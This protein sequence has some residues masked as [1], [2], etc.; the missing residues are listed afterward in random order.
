MTS[1]INE[2]EL[3]KAIEQIHPD[4]ELFEVRIINKVGKKSN[5]ISGYFKDAETLLKKLKTINLENTNVY[6]TLNQLNEGLFSRQQSET[7]I[8]GAN[9]TSDNDVDGLNWLFIDLD[10]KRAAGI[11][12]SKEELQNAYNLASKVYEYLKNLGFEEPVKAVS[13]NGAHLLYRIKLANN[14]TNRALVEKC[15]KT[16]SMIFD[17][18]KI[19]VDT[20]TF[21]PARIC[22]LYGTMAQKGKSTESR[23]HRMSHIIGEVKEV[24]ATDRAYLEKLVGELPQEAP[25]P[26]KYNNYSPAEFDIENWL[27]KYGLN[28]TKKDFRDGIKYVLDECPFDSS[29]K[30]PDSMVT[31]T[32][33]GAIGFKCLHNSCA[34]KHWRDLRLKFEPDAYEYSNEDRRI[35][36]GY[37]RHNREQNK[38]L[39]KNEV[40][41]PTFVNANMILHTDDPEGEYIKSGINVIDKKMKGLQKGCVSLVSGLRGAAKT[42]ILGQII[43]NCVEHK[44]TAVVYSGELSKKRFLNWLMIQA[45]GK[46]YT[47]KYREYEG[48]YCQDL[49]KPAICNWLGNYMWLYNNICGN[50]FDEIAALIKAK[51]AEYKADICI[52]DNLMAL[53]LGSY[54][55]DQYVAQ[56]QFVWK[57]KEIA[58]ELNV[59]VIFV[60]HPRKAMGFLRLDD[61][62]GSGNITNIVDNAFIIHRNNNDFQRLTKSMFGWKQDNEA[63]SGSNVIEI[64]KDRENGNQDIFIP[65]WFEPESKRLKNYDTENIVYS[66]EKPKSSYPDDFMDVTEDMLK[67]IP[68]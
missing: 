28:Y 4:G 5:V 51:V 31:V 42:T 65:L 66:W 62:S 35:D 43:L 32:P 40:A 2:I 26:N 29:H 20:S 58:T 56:T 38:I 64:C 22:K 45:A 9:T 49:V 25:K 19:E 41:E 11:S 48:Y 59:H 46:S 34:D 3:R 6:F 18:D 17:T 39:S 14:D 23:P 16:L 57:L 61:V 60:A 53:D 13:G 50:R 36:E 68:F 8:N 52:I 67:E 7:F 10:P 30:A 63:Y 21:N 12:S 15:L 1:Y 55:K 44:Q 54:D 33:S 24:K 37:L 47:K 27:N